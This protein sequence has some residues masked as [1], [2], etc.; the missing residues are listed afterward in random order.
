MMP[1][2][3]AKGRRDAEME[4]RSAELLER[5]GLSHVADNKATNMSGGQQQRV[6]DRAGAGDAARSRARRRAD[7]Q[8]RYTL[9][10][11]APSS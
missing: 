3:V 2:L 5:V 6:G 9:P 10:P 7:G 4:R 8:S 1:M 11:K